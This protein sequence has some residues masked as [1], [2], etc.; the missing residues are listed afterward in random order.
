MGGN[1]IKIPGLEEAGDEGRTTM[2]VTRGNKA[3]VTRNN[4]FE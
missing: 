2:E 1:N 4:S 3:R